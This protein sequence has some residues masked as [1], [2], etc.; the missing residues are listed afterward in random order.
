M[1]IK[2]KLEGLIYE[3]MKEGKSELGTYRLVKAELEKEEVKGKTKKTLTEAEEWSI[4]LK[5]IKTREESLLIYGKNGRLDL[6]EK[7][8]EEIETIKSI[9]PPEA[10]ISPDDIKAAANEVLDKIDHP[11]TMKDCGFVIKEVLKKYPAADRGIISQE[12]KKRGN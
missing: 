2:E 10:L 5:M 9:L 4:L 3:A 1:T 7:E 12:V 11:I 6:V 8:E